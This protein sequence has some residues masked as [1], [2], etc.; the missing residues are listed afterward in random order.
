M[1]GGPPFRTTGRIGALGQHSVALAL[2]E[3][4]TEFCH[5]NFQGQRHALLLTHTEEALIRGA[6]TEREVV[7]RI[8]TK[9]YT[10]VEL[11]EMTLKG[12]GQ[13]YLKKNCM[14]VRR[15]TR[16]TFL[17][18]TPCDYRLKGA[19]RPEFPAWLVEL[20]QGEYVIYIIKMMEHSCNYDVFFEC[21]QKQ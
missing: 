17:H 10:P 2:D 5:I 9:H 12:K 7:R 20:A 1:V 21:F 19:A 15:C 14:Q 8:L 3:S 4:P 18:R 6:T 11:Q 16:V 13:A